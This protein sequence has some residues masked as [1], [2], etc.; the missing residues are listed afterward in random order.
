MRNSR[1]QALVREY[2]QAGHPLG[3]AINPEE[4]PR[5]ITALRRRLQ[6]T[7][8]ELDLSPASLA[9]L[10]TRLIALRHAVQARQLRMDEEETVRLIREITASLGQVLVTNL[11]A[12]WEEESLHL[13]PGMLWVA[14]PVEAIKGHEVHGSQRRGFVATDNAAYFWDLLGTGEGRGFLVTEYNMMTRKRWKEQL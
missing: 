6:C 10:E 5:L 11:D 1:A 14:P 12:H 7:A 4:V 2:G 13:W 9:Q 8:Q 3:H